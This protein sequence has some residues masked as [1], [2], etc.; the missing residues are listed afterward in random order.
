MDPV[1]KRIIINADDLGLSVRVNDTTFDLMEHGRVTSAT[2]MMNAPAVD[3]AKRRLMRFPNCSFGVHLNVTECESLSHHSGLAPLLSN[4]GNFNAD[5][6]L[7]RTTPSLLRGVYSEWCAQ[8]ERA[9]AMRIPVSHLDSHHH[10]H[11]APKLFPVLKQVQRRYN[12]C[13]VRA[14][15]NIYPQEAPASKAR[16]ASKSLWNTAVRFFP[17]TNTPDRF[18]NFE[19]FLHAASCIRPEHQTLELMTHPGS[20]AGDT[21]EVSLLRSPWEEKMPFAVSLISY[22]DL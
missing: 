5:V 18:A 9:F 10:V 22:N 17:T 12:I 21:R 20:S 4:E 3:D 7:V 13:R 2:L 6:R 11:T 15:L 14:S 1:T 16:L 8:I 19:D